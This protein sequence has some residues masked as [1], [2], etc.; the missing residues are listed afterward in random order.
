MSGLYYNNGNVH[1]VGLFGTSCN[2]TIKNVGVVDSYLKGNTYVAGICGFCY[3]Y[4]KGSV[5]NCF[6]S[7]TISGKEYVGGVCGYSLGNTF[8]H[9]YNT[10]QV[11]GTYREIGGLCGSIMGGSCENSYNTG[12]VTGINNRDQ[13]GGVCGYMDSLHARATDTYRTPGSR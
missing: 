9:N 5:T 7:S 4:D 13:L 8:T 10:G 3:K 1:Y 6:N 11:S 2:E 12:S